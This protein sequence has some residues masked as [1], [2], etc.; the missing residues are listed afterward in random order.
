MTAH[1]G[2]AG[3]APPTPAAATVWARVFLTLGDRVVVAN[4]RGLPWFFLLGERVAPGEGVEQVLHRILRRAAG[5]EVRALD[6]VGGMEHP[7]GGDGSTREIDVI[8]AGT[9]PRFAEF[10]SRLEELDLVTVRISELHRVGFR[11][12][13][14]G[15]VVRAWLDE[16]EPR[17]HTDGGSPHPPSVATT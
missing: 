6:F 12:A 13:H 5:L 11:P 10:G 16:R 8:F 4:H 1:P 3:P 14:V 7:G 17:W 9:V 2:P 15:Q